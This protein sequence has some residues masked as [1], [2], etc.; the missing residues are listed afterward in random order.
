MRSR[1]GR[2]GVGQE[3][4]GEV[5][6]RLRTLAVLG[7]V[8]GRTDA[9]LLDAFGRGGEERDLAF[10][11]LVDRHGPM[12]MRV[13]RGVLGDGP[14]A[15]DAFQATFLVLIRKAG[16]LRARGTVGPWLYQ[17]A[18]RVARG[19]RAREN[20]RRHHER[21]AAEI[22]PAG[23]GDEPLAPGEEAILH[24]EIAGLPERF[25]AP[26]VLC[27]LEGWS[28]ERAAGQ[29]GCAV[30][31]IKSRLYRGRERLRSRLERRGVGLAVLARPGGG[32]VPA[33]LVKSTL[34]L[35]AGPVRAGAVATL[36]EGAF[37]MMGVAQWRVLAAQGLVAASVLGGAVA[38]AGAFR[39]P[40]Q[41]PAEV[42][43]AGARII[44]EPARAGQRLD[45]KSEIE[46][47]T[48]VIML[49]PE[50]TRVKEK[51]LVC[52]LDTAPVTDRLELQ[53][54]E[55]ERA[56]MA[57]DAASDAYEI[58]QLD[59][60]VFEKGIYPGE[61]AA[62]AGEIELA[63]GML[64]LEQARLAAV[65]EGVDLEKRERNLAVK[66]AELALQEAGRRKNFLE[67]W[68]REIRIKTLEAAFQKASAEMWLAEAE[69]K[70]QMEQEERLHAMIEKGKVYASA[71]GVV[72]Y[73][74]LGPGQGGGK[75]GEGTVVRERQALFHIEV[76]LAQE[77]PGGK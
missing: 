51:Q 73:A 27:E 12:V 38:L 75:V 26:L 35:A 16:G 9:Q 23:G 44:E 58:A 71:D 1:G 70:I 3:G 55:T 13:C 31:T 43:A 24:E 46:G 77:G 25:R 65:Q 22:G 48:T 41:E 37:R 10:E 20:L 53:R 54:L 36:A 8:G 21:K 50:G 2:T 69:F 29:L 32:V 5:V 62:M 76:E 52:E 42:P 68:T 14:D 60:V 7:A 49:L 47:E 30:G 39:G 33:A 63:Q 40:G 67:R 28:H 34:E 57:Y 4:R 66:K 11:V 15:L 18:W 59:L 45:A 6:Q 19:A 56:K 74:R 17:V 64:E 61:V 72:V